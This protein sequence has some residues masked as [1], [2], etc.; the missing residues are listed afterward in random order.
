[1]LIAR[2]VPLINDLIIVSHREEILESIP[3]QRAHKLVLCAVGVLK[4]INEPVRMRPAIPRSNRGKGLH[5][6]VSFK[7]QGIEVQSIDVPQLLL[8]ELI[9]RRNPLMLVQARQRGLGCRRLNEL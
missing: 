1:M 8:V 3:G 4:F 6:A 5:K 7:N 9:C 2:T